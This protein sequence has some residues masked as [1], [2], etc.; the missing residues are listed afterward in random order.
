MYIDDVCLKSITGFCCHYMKSQY[1]AT[2]ILYSKEELLSE[3][4]GEPNELLAHLQSDTS[5][6]TESGEPLCGNI[7]NQISDDKQQEVRNAFP[8]VV[9]L[10]L[11]PGAVHAPVSIQHLNAND[12]TLE[13][14]FQQWLLSDIRQIAIL[15]KHHEVVR[16]LYSAKV[17]VE[18]HAWSCEAV[19]DDTALVTHIR[20]VLQMEVERTIF[21][22]MGGCQMYITRDHTTITNRFIL[23][24]L[25]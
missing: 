20:E 12:D 1:D 21:I 25:L 22:E 2:W 5:T 11:T 8:P 9:N 24:S 10:C 15:N 17:N 19:F 23:I 18:T 4:N 3:L 14:L 6:I 13:K 16:V 7:W